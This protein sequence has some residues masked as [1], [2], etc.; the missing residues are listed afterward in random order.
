MATT[1][2]I[3]I[4]TAIPG[5][6]S[7]EILERKQRVIANAKSIV[8]PIVA[9]EGRGATLTDVDGNTFIDFTGGV[10]CLNTGH[11]HPARRRGR[12]RAAGA[13]RAHRLHRRP[14]RA[15]RRARRAPAREGAV[16][17]PGEGRVLQRRHR[18]RRERGQVRAPLHEA[19]RRDRLRGRVPRPHAALDD[20]DLAAAPVQGR[21]GPAGAGG[22]PG[23]VPVRLPRPRHRDRAR[24]APP[25]VP[26]AGRGG[27]GRGDHRRAGAGRGRLPA[28]ADRRSSRD[29]GRS[30]TS[31]ASA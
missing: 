28:R 25:D 5:P 6:R 8:L 2:T 23:A 13:V 17:R 7:Q 24:R 1:K 19:P 16:P 12:H 27:A 26:D 3:D 14:L 18:G 29:C 21:H 15:V 20:P 31:T 4:R 11:A 10:G 22:V 9:H 30:A